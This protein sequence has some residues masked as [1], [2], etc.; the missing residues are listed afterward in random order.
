M[1]RVLVL[2]VVA[3]AIA[4]GA[5]L[6][7]PSSALTVNADTLSQSHL[8]DELAAIQASPSYQCFFESQAYV[9]GLND[10]A[11]VHGVAAP[12]WFTTPT[13]EWTNTRTTQLAIVGYVEAHY[14]S[15]LSAP[16]L[17]A[18]R[19][20][21]ESAMSSTIDAAYVQGQGR[22]QG[23][24]CSGIAAPTA[25]LGAQA[26]QSM[27]GWFQDEQIQA[28]AAELELQQLTPSALP[29]SGV[30]LEAWYHLHAAEFA[31][32]CLSLIESPSLASALA[33]SARIAHGLPFAE[34]AKQYS[35]DPTTASKGGA[36][37]CFSPASPEWA[38]VQHYS[39]HVPTGH[40]SAPQPIPSSTAYLIVEVTKRTSNSFE[41]VHTAVVAQ[42]EASNRAAA[43]LLAVEIQGA[44]DIAVSPTIGTWVPTTAGGTIVPPSAPPAASVTNPT[45]NVPA[46]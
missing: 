5:G 23:F 26:L 34:A 29:T 6:A 33:V 14:P 19:V 35:K 17:A 11:P 10:P 45:A 37:G 8:N 4:V 18:A 22:S 46:P 42:N 38:A 25:T 43:Q 16:S 36:L 15:A 28:N 9:N 7:I 12:T 2:V 30:A 44:A 39:A 20:N 3:A 31:T 27:P 40:V 32:T 21:L 41:Q 13:V 24:S 1:R